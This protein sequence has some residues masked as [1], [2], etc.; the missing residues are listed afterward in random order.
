MISKS[1]N[2]QYFMRGS[3]RVFAATGPTLVNPQ[4]VLAASF[5]ATGRSPGAASSRSLITIVSVRAVW[6]TDPWTPS[7]RLPRQLQFHTGRQRDDRS[8]PSIEQ[9]RDLVVQATH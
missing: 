5:Q 2:Y 1:Q 4:S 7:T 3:L 6:L 9:H 8:P